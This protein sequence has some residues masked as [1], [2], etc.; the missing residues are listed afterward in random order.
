MKYTQIPTNTFKQLQMNAGILLS[1]FDPATGT[2]PDDA[3]LGATTGGITFTATPTFKDFG[4]DIDNCPKNTMELKKLESW[5]AKL[6]GVFV[7]VTAAM[8]KKLASAA[9]LASIKVTPR[10]DVLVSD[11]FDLWWVGDYSE[12]N[13]GDDAGFCAVHLLNGLSTGGVQIKSADKD[14]GQFTFEFTGHYSMDAQDTVPYEIYVKSGEEV[15][16]AFVNLNRH[17]VGLTVG[18]TYQLSATKFPAL[19]TVTWSSSATSK[20]TVSNGLVTAVAA[21]SAIITAAITENSVTYT[22]TCTV[23][24]TAAS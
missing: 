6:S 23:I 4:E 22:D 15:A 21:G 7:T 3:I 12:V 9:D 24:V 14:K 20:A 16:Y 2:I 10:N 8:A 11:F 5:E 18:D 13:S 19:S 17:A 1:D